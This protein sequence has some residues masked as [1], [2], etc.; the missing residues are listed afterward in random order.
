MFRA[1]NPSTNDSFDVVWDL[2]RRCTYAC[3]YCGPHHSNK[4]SPHTSLETLI[5]T[6]DGVVEY[7]NKLN[8]Y[9]KEEKVTSLAFTGGEPTANPDFFKFIKYVKENYKHLH[10]NVTTNGCYSKRKN[11]MVMDNCDNCTLSYHAEATGRE[12]ALVLDNIKAMSAA[13]Y[14]F[15]VNLMFHKDYFDECILIAELLDELEVNYVPRVIGDSNNKSD[16]E[17]GTAHVYDEEQMQW[18]KDY[19]NKD[20]ETTSEGT[21]GDG[22]SIGRPCCNRKP[23]DLLIDDEW[24]SGTFVP[25]TNF[26]GWSCMVNWDFLFIH[27]ELDEVWHHQ[28]CQINMDSEIGP[29]GKASDF[30]SINKVLTNNL[31]SGTMPVIRCPKTWCGCG[32]CSPKALDDD[33]FTNIFTD[34]IKDLTPSLQKSK[35]LKGIKIITRLSYE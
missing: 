29:I 27:S 9:R 33:V 34:R 23:M 16:I 13:N 22:V 35:E 6:I 15:K 8:G 24:K 1:I 31:S 32:L 19:W 21:C 11:Q 30:K 18:F 2:G 14:N 3:T 17:D 25:S 10:I 5:N 7:T 4:T 12:K 26:K 28:T 20:N